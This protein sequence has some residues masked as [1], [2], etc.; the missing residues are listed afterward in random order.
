M[1]LSLTH[2]I[3][4]D[5]DNSVGKHHFIEKFIDNRTNFRNNLRLTK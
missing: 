5:H 3:L 2:H 1:I 4:S